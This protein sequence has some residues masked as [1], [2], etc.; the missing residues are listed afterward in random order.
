MKFYEIDNETVY[1]ISIFKY[2]Q[3]IHYNDRNIADLAIDLSFATFATAEPSALKIRTKS[4]V[5]E[6]IFAEFDYEVF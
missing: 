5:K 4:K 1:S 3:V 2:I 6:R